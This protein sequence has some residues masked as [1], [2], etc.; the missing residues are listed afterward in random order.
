MSDDETVIEFWFLTVA[1]TYVFLISWSEDKIS[2]L[3]YETV[4]MKTQNI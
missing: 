1:A 3:Y 2:C 4:D